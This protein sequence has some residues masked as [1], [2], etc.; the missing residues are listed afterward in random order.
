[1]FQS[2][3]LEALFDFSSRFLNIT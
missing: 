2:S 3:Y 1:M